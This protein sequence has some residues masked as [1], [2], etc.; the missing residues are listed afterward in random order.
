MVESKKN[1]M[2]V[3][4]LLLAVCLL[5]A[6]SWIAGYNHWVISDAIYEYQM[7]CIREHR[8]MFVDYDDKEDFYDTYWRM[9][10]WGYK[11]ILPEE[12]YTVLRPY[13]GR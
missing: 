1:Q 2:R 7:E 8:E 12:K 11:R 9:W 4:V 5:M 3:L 13:I 10:D 6:K